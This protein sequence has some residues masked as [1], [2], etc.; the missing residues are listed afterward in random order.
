MPI[1]AKSQQR[2]R[3]LS[4]V[5]LDQN[6]QLSPLVDL[7]NRVVDLPCDGLLM[8]RKLAEVLQINLGDRMTIEILEGK[9]AT[10]E[11]PVL[12]FIDDA[13]GETI[14]MERFR[15]SELLQE[16]PLATAAYL[17]I[18]SNLKSLVISELERR[19]HVS[20]VVATA[21][22]KQSFLSTIAENVR[23]MRSINLF[24]SIVIAIGVI[25][26]TAR[27][28]IA[29]RSR[30]LATLR[31]LGFSRFEVTSIIVLEL[32]ILTMLAI[33]MGWLIGYGL[34]YMTVNAFDRE[35]FRVP[36]V[37]SISTYSFAA[38]VVVGAMLGAS[39]LIYGL[40]GKMNFVDVLKARD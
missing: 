39:W 29:E 8:S 24:F 27:I 18:D 15:L 40:I 5:G 19:P 28:S 25:Y 1:R 16:T 32:A 38:M 14:Y 7:Q 33:P 3:L 21:D 4:I 35:L 2:E 20:H 23:R 6:H 26:S 36:F 10:L 31:V 17:R 13:A 30:E 22:L 11:I 37:I 9:R 34:S 12:E